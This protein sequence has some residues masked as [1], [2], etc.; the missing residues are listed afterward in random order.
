MTIKKTVCQ[1]LF[2][3]LLTVGALSAAAPVTA[4]PVASV[5]MTESMVRLTTPT[6][7]QSNS[8]SSSS[9]RVSGRGVRGLGR[10]IVFAV[11]ALLGVG[12]WLL[13]KMSGE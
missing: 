2:C 7:A 1:T 4:A 5:Q 11:V 13:G 9:G 10:L 6:L 3:L 8:D 12:K